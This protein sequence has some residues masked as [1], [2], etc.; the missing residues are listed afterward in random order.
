MAMRAKKTARDI[1]GARPT[2][3]RSSLFRNVRHVQIGSSRACE[4]KRYVVAI[5]N[6]IPFPFH[7][8]PFFLLRRALMRFFFLVA[9]I[10]SDAIT[11]S[12]TARAQH[13]CESGRKR[14]R[15]QS[16]NGAFAFAFSY[17]EIS[18]SSYSRL[19]TRCRRSY[20]LSFSLFHLRRQHDILFYTFFFSPSISSLENARQARPIADR[21]IT[22]YFGD[23]FYMFSQ[24]KRHND[25]KHRIMSIVICCNC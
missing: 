22:W 15:Y 21:H 9:N 6:I 19:D 1:S 2:R 10:Q 5:H 8:V 24:I 14:P 20:F 7:P 3:E 23:G 12:W 11:K 18:S 4:T 16:Q 17:L 13:A 25:S